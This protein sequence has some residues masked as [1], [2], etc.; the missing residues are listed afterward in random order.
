MRWLFWNLDWAKLDVEAHRDAILGRVLE[1]GKLV[2]VKW[3]VKQY[4]G[5]AIRDFFRRGP[6]PEVS[7]KTVRFWHAV[8]HAEEPWPEQ[9]AFRQSSS[10]PWID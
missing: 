3:A 4:G 10:A 1:R 9:P 7:A 6:H 2:D 8:L 5:D